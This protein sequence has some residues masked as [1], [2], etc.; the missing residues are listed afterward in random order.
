MLTGEQPFGCLNHA[1][2][3]SWQSFLF[4]YVIWQV[5]KKNPGILELQKNNNRYILISQRWQIHNRIYMLTHQWQ[6]LEHVCYV[7]SRKYLTN[8]YSGK[9]VKLRFHLSLAQQDNL[10]VIFLSWNKHLSCPAYL[11]LWKNY[12]YN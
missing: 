2:L 6:L 8:S 1:L 5:S 9:W 10:N 11:K 3:T 12:K 7:I 4:R